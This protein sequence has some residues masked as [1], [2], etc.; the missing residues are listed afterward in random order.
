MFLLSRYIIGK[1]NCSCDG[2]R[3]YVD[4]CLKPSWFR[5]FLLKLQL[6]LLE[7]ERERER[8]REK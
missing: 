6:Q 7:K 3:K 2:S 4:V 1:V 5:F 8:E